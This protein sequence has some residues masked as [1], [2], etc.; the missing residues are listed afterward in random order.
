MVEKNCEGRTKR[1][2]GGGYYLNKTVSCYRRTSR[3]KR[4]KQDTSC[5]KG[6]PGAEDCGEQRT[7]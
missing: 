5:N 1:R 6:I 2:K 7:G 3:A 4:Q